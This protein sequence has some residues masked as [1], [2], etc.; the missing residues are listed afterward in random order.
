VT[1]RQVLKLA[2]YLLACLPFA[3]VAEKESSI[4]GLPTPFVGVYWDCYHDACPKLSEIPTDA[5]GVGGYNTIF[6]FQVLPSGTKG[7]LR[8]D[9]SSAQTVASLKTDIAA[10]RAAGI[11]VRLTFGGAGG[12]LAISSPAIATTL[13]SSL[14]T[15]IDS[16]GPVDGLDW[17]IEGGDLYPTEMTW[18]GQQLKSIYGSDFVITMAPKPDDTTQARAAQTMYQGGALDC[19]SPQFYEQGALTHAEMI[20]NVTDRIDNI[21][22]PAVGGNAAAIGLGFELA[23]ADNTTEDY[24]GPATAVTCW[25]NVQT[26]HPGLRGAFVWNASEEASD[27]ALFINDV[28]PS[29]AGRTPAPTPIPSI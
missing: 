3:I 9:C 23:A 11:S 18:I 7:D 10:K 1:R 19:V 6:I 17:D 29:I 21:W 13:V 24:M 14:Q 28:A 20:S 4:S 12:Y 26:A 22:L 15:I 16:I 8:F 27:G 25:Q 2:G 5:T